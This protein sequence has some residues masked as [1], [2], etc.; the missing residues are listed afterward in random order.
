MSI[1][2]SYVQV[3]SAIMNVQNR[4]KKNWDKFVLVGT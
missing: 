1:K 3:S 4:S 2:E